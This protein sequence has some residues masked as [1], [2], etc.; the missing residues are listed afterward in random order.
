VDYGFCYAAFQKLS[1]LLSNYGKAEEVTLA[2]A[3]LEKVQLFLGLHAFG[4]HVLIQAL[5]C[6]LG[7]FVPRGA[8]RSAALFME[9]RYD[10]R[11]FISTFTRDIADEEVALFI[12]RTHRCNG[13]L[14]G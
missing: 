1:E 9:N 3:V 5:F 11:A 4:D 8:A 6:C 13:H 14:V 10:R 7:S 12:L 2:F